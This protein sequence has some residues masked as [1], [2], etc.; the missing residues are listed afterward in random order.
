MKITELRLAPA[1]SWEAPG[2]EN[3]M[4]C[5][6]KLASK[7]SVVQTVIPQDMMEELIRLVCGIVS[8]AATNNVADFA[9]TV[10]QIES[11]ASIKAIAGTAEWED[12]Q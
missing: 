3:N 10:S 1:R 8:K 11:G 4:V 12:N 7:D 6:V 9:R 2:L 5:T